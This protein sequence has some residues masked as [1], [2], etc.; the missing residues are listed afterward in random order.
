MRLTNARGID[1]IFL[2]NNDFKK[3]YELGA[4]YTKNI[5]EKYGQ[6]EYERINR[7]FQFL[8]KVYSD[9]FR[10]PSFWIQLYDIADPEMRALTYYYHWEKLSI[11]DQRQKVFI[12]CNYS[13]RA[14]HQ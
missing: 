7:R 5:I 11:N 14:A 12:I 3:A 4:E 9:K 10:Q 6:K 13:L 1:A 2:R 8:A